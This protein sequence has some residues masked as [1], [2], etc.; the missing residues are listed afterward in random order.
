MQMKDDSFV[1]PHLH[2]QSWSLYAS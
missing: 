2:T 1:H